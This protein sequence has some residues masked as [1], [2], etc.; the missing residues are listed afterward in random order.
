MSSTFHLRWSPHETIKITIAVNQEQVD[1]GIK[2]LVSNHH[3]RTRSIGLDVIT[4]RDPWTNTAK[5]MLLQL[6]DGIQCLIIR[7]HC[8]DADTLPESL[9]NFLSLPAF[10]FSRFG[11]E[12]TMSLLKKDYCLS[13]KNTLEVGRS[14]WYHPKKSVTDTL[15]S[16][17]IPSSSCISDVWDA[18]IDL[19]DEMVHVAASNA[20]GAFRLGE[21]FRY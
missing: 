18:E 17:L 9:Y 2:A 1:E 21:K 5:A 20:F 19:A 15:W 12:D 14:V 13:C 11:I 4:K 6:S 16:M 7:L 3:N 10:T 8:L